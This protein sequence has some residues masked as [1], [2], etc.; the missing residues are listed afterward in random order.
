MC[1]RWI[2]APLILT[3]AACAGA[4][5]NDASTDEGATTAAPKPALTAPHVEDAD[6]P[7]I[8]GVGDDAAWATATATTYD[9]DWS[10]KVWPKSVTTVRSLWNE[11]AF[12]MLWEIAGTSFNTDHS[13]PVDVEREDLYNEDCVEI[14]FTPNPADINHYFEIELGPFGHF[15]DLDIHHA[16]GGSDEKWSSGAQIKTTQD[17][18]NH[19][20]IIEVAF[21]S[22][23]MLA[24]LKSG[25]TLPINMFRMEAKSPNREYLA[26]SP[27]K[28]PRPNFHV[29]AAFGSLILK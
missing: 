10:G 27:T 6:V 8:D 11:H 1:M 15:F 23:D 2:V 22:P 16:T 20:A 14:F 17:V 3:V 24:A 26:W 21:T 25:A 7:T 12:Y 9:T 4:T 18:P 19:K 28:T 13:K 29:P 5:S